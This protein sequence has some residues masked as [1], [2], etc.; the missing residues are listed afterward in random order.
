[1]KKRNDQNKPVLENGTVF[2]ERVFNAPSAQI[3]EAL[4]DKNKMKEWYFDVPDFKP[5]VGQEF[6]F[7]GGE[8]GKEYMHLCKVVEVIPG[9]KISYTWRYEGYSGNSKVSFELIP[10]GEKTRVRLIHEGLDTFPSSNPDFKATN[11]VGGWTH[12]MEKGLP[13]YLEKGK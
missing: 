8:D 4:T 11:F 7:K 13:E 3:W 10:E 2:L 1:M 6:S 5:E 12:F 9:R